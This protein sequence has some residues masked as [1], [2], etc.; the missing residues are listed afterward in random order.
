[1]GTECWEAKN[2]KIHFNEDNKDNK[3]S[4]IIWNEEKVKAGE[5]LTL[6][7]NKILLEKAEKSICEIIKDTGY[8]SGF[9]CKIKYPNNYNEEIFALITKNHAIKKDMLTNKEN[10]KIKLNNQELIILLKLNRRIWTNEIIDFTCIEII[11]EDNIIE[12][13]NPFEIDDN[14]YNINYNIK[15]YN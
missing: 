9:F 7:N 6:M 14:C 10:I 5:N 11:K 13:I 2:N 3:A 8:G 1:M 15:E 4:L 12:I